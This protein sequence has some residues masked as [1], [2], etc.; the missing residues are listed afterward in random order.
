M[1]PEEVKAR[2]QRGLTIAATTKLVKKGQVWIV[3]SQTGN[4]KYTVC[5]DAATPH[6]SCPDHEVHGQRCKHIYAVQYTI[7]RELFDDGT[8]AVTKTLTVTETV[9][10]PSYKQDWANYNRA[11]ENEKDKFQVLLRDLCQ[12]LPDNTAQPRQRG[13]QPFP[14]R[15]A[16]FSACYKVFTTMSGRRF[17]SD[18]REAKEDGYVTRCP[19]KSM[20]FKVLENPAA[21]HYLRMLVVESAA[22]L[23]EIE[24]TFACDS[25]GFSGSRFDRWF[26]HKHGDRKIRRAWVKAH[27]MCGVKTNVI[28]AVEIHGQHAGDS[29]QLPPLLETTSQRFKPIEVCGDLGFSSAENLY[30][31]ARAGATPLIPFK[32]NARL[33]NSRLW[34]YML[35]HFRLHRE[36]FLSRYHQRSNVESTFSM[37]KAKFGDSV[38]SK[39]DVA[40]KNEVLAKLV[41][42]NIACLISAMYELG[43]DPQFWAEA[44]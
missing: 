36:A 28:T 10:K 27:V 11:Q 8:E 14:F 13:N 22:P 32:S 39:T 18:M 1:T 9:R 24:S 38:R 7:Q 16:I 3:P 17:M 33:G 23:K 19:S 15:D 35:S 30:A 21:F 12:G 37:V 2:E 43:V 6:C 41:C 40:M 29:P 26:D 44:S 4:G 5:P 31:I 25:S 20:V 42:H 34:D